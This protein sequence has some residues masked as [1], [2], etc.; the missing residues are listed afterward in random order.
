MCRTAK[1]RQA[2]QQLRCPPVISEQPSR[3]WELACPGCYVLVVSALLREREQCARPPSPGTA[4]SAGSKLA[5]AA[6]HSVS[7]GWIFSYSHDAVWA[8][9]KAKA[10]AEGTAT[11]GSSSGSLSWMPF[12]HPWVLLSHCASVFAGESEVHI[13][14]DGL[15]QPMVLLEVI[16]R[17]RLSKVGAPVIFFRRALESLRTASAAG[18]RANISTA[19]PMHSH[20]VSLQ[21]IESVR[22]WTVLHGS[23]FDLQ[24]RERPGEL[25]EFQ[26]LLLQVA[27]AWLPKPAI[28]LACFQIHFVARWG[29]MIAH[30]GHFRPSCH[31]TG[32]WQTFKLA[33][34][35][36]GRGNADEPEKVAEVRGLAVLPAL[37]CLP[38][39]PLDGW[40]STCLKPEQHQNKD[41]HVCSGTSGADVFRVL[42]GVEYTADE[43]EA[44][45]ELAPEV[46][47]GSVV[48]L[49][50]ELTVQDGDVAKYTQQNF[51]GPLLC[52]VPSDPRISKGS[53]L[54]K[55]L[56][57]HLA[58]TL[59]I[60]PKLVP[61]PAS[62]MPRSFSGR[63]RR[64]SSQHLHHL[65]SPEDILPSEWVFEEDFK[66]YELSTES[67][68][69]AEDEDVLEE[70]ME[71]ASCFHR[72]EE[73]AQRSKPVVLVLSAGVDET[74]AYSMALATALC[75]MT[76]ASWVARLVDEAD[77]TRHSEALA[78]AGEAATL[79]H[80]LQTDP[81][82]EGEAKD[83]TSLIRIL[84]AWDKGLRQRSS[85]AQDQ[86]SVLQVL[87]VSI[88]R[89]ARL[90]G[91]SSDPQKHLLTGV[92]LSAAEELPLRACHVDV[93]HSLAKADPQPLG[94]KLAEVIVSMAHDL[95][96]N[97]GFPS[98]LFLDGDAKRLARRLKPVM[99]DASPAS[100]SFRRMLLAGGAGGVG[101]LWAQFLKAETL[102]LLGRS[103]P[104]GKP[105]NALSQLKKGS[106]EVVYVQADISNSEQL[107]NALQNCAVQGLDFACSLC[108][109]FVPP[110]AL[111]E[112]DAASSMCGP[113]RKLRGAENFVSALTSLH[114]QAAAK[115]QLPILFT[116]SAV[117]VNGASQL[118]QY[119]AGVRALEAFCARARCRGTGCDVRCVALSA[120]DGVGI[121]DKF[122]LLAAA[123]PA[124][125]LKV[126]TPQMGI[127]A[128]E[129]VFQRFTSPRFGVFG[130][131]AERVRPCLLTPNLV[132]KPSSLQAELFTGWQANHCTA[133]LQ[134]RSGWGPT[135]NQSVG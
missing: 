70:R 35:I 83:V 32:H 92:L 119:A 121:T 31:T 67:R 81:S 30:T 12:G 115:T 17:H 90:A 40:V 102:I 46:L 129:S 52:F 123:A 108:E 112:L 44:A 72:P 113:L 120:W 87:C 130:C 27:E 86:S 13:S 45:L 21:G 69:E 79:I 19:R 85:A 50:P 63:P 124:A 135:K 53:G 101:T 105:Q 98:E 26:M 111:R 62:R 5:E 22:Q 10:M 36:E 18:G 3:S 37:A 88:G 38:S 117:S 64:P 114:K 78:K 128:L 89:S 1:T 59:G 9:V 47:P 60:A 91:A 131:R 34:G 73:A 14:M 29:A 7:E 71:G 76:T 33:A 16:A 8:D 39:M 68:T 56:G 126:L 54:V 132:E 94:G 51:E 93:A 41:D 2:W 127:L 100:P 134:G 96:T 110:H 20:F 23:E 109:S 103:L 106:S 75:S 80:L 58:V 24:C 125:G 15:P 84:Q 116:S 133:L 61:V 42:G 118:A 97:L 65:M 57:C 99:L 11:S 55:S 48:A 74:G 28:A 25:E 43:L 95:A 82:C 6:F 49:M 4:G 66:P 122:P 104:R 107:R 77:A